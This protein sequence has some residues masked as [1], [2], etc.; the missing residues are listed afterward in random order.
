MKSITYLQGDATHPI[1]VGPKIV[2]H[3]CNNLGVWGAGFVLALS[4]RWPQPEASYRNLAKAEVDNIPLGLVQYVCVCDD[5]TVANIIGQE[6]VSI[7]RG[8]PPIRYR[9]LANGLALVSHHAIDCRATVHLPRLGCGLAGGRWN[10]VEALIE[11]TLCG[12]GVPV[13]VYDFAPGGVP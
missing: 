6:G 3:C 8:L 13:F 2:A 12:Y 9:A 1:G 4:K 7:R 11:E 10:I 5:I